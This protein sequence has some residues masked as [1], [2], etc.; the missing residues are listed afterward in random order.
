MRVS[1]LQKKKDQKIKRFTKN[2]SIVIADK[3][4]LTAAPKCLEKKGKRNVY[5]MIS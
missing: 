2:S 4:S 3:T 5:L 1:S